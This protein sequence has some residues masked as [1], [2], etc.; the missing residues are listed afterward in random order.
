MATRKSIWILIEMV[1][2]M[3]WLLGSVT[4]ASAQTYTI[5]CRATGHF[6]KVNIIEI[7]DV[8][9]HIVAV[10]ESAGVSSC[11]D[12]SIATTSSKFMSDQTKGNGK[13]TSY[14]VFTFED[15]SAL[16]AKEEFTITANP[17][18][19]TGR[20]EAT[21]EDIKGTGRFE[22]VQGSGSYIGR[23]LASVPGVGAQWYIDST[24]TY[25]LP[26]K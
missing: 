11:D 21:F 16:W 13:A 10:G 7:G 26:S 1:I 8:P 25:T 18:G 5:K 22:G 23:R 12:G 2:I 3:A 20:W 24:G 15:G 14:A 4:Q 19:K 17:D 6:A 9:G